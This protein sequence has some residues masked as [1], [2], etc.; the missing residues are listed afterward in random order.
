MRREALSWNEIPSDPNDPIFFKPL[1]RFR[2]CQICDAF[3][4]EEINQ[5]EIGACRALL[6]GHNPVVLYERL[7]VSVVLRLLPQRVDFRRSATLDH[8]GETRRLCSKQFHAR[9]IRI[10][11]AR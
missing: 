7:K 2:E 10:T 1:Q 4:L 5:P 6:N 8:D 3:P 11:V 9:G